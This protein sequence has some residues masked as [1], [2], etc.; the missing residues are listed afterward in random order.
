MALEI[1]GELGSRTRLYVELL[2][3][4]KMAI[5]CPEIACAQL[6]PLVYI[7]T[8]GIRQGKIP[9]MEFSGA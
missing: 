5:A 4:I 2:G 3:K 6:I 1:T 7:C 9:E 8:T